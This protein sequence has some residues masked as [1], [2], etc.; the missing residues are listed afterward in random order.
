MSTSQTC[1]HLPGKILNSAAECANRARV[2]KL[3]IFDLQKLVIDA[4]VVVFCLQK[5]FTFTLKGFFYGCMKS[6]S[7][8]HQ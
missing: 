7:L 3:F 5:L 1:C 2:E 8:W 4:S 6:A